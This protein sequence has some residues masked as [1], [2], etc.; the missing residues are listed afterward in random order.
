MS[1]TAPVGPAGEDDGFRRALADYLADEVLVDWS[2]VQI[3]AL[4]RSTGGLS[5]ETF[6]VE[7]V[8][9]GHLNRRRK[10]VVKRPPLEG[11]LAP[12]DLTKQGV[13]VRALRDS[14][15][16][17]APV[18]GFTS[19][20]AVAG[21]QVEVMQYVEGEIPDLRSIEAWPAWKDPSRRSLVGQRVL[22]VLA[23]VQAFDWRQPQVEAVLAG[24]RSV[25]DHVGTVI[26]RLMDKVDANFARRWA[27]D[28]LVRDV[29]LWLHDNIPAIDDRELVVV[30]GDFRIG[31]FI[32]KG[33]EV[34]AL[35]DWERATLGD[36][37]HDLGFFCM[38]MARQR[39]P[40]LM[41]ML[42]SV[43]QLVDGYEKATDRAVDLRRL[44]YYLI[45]W[46]FVEVA[47]VLNAIV[48]LIE[49]APPN[50]MTS[51]NSY[52]LISSGTIDLVDLIERFED[53]DHALI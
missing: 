43:D 28:P 23:Q 35:L 24:G 20:P 9:R 40:E 38:P 34:A 14:A 32:W 3:D 11:P 29:W 44:H 50:D 53:G 51:L 27:P 13:L 39:H 4:D 37:M 31:N 41:G 45:Y 18:L 15:V 46:Q 36:P 16:P 42:L 49:R 48:Y 2:G 17:V 22:E 47:Q 33:D 10:L 6:V 1:Q 52:S 26:D 21:R 8:E 25:V 30:H 19:E 5:W 7:V 12:Y